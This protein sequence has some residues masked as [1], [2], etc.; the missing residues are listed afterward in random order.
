MKYEPI[1]IKDIAQALNLSISTVSRALRDSYEISQETKRLVME[2]AEKMNYRPNPV[3][4]SL[5]ERRTRSIGIV[6]S[7]IANSFFSQAIN[8][9]ESIA[10]EKGYTVIITQTNESGDR[11]MD[12]I[13]DLASRSVDGLLISLSCETT[14]ISHLKSM[15]E[16][17]MPMVF[18]DRV[19][20]GI[21]THK[22]VSDNY[23]GAFDATEH[24]IQSGYSR[25]AFL[26]N[27]PHLSII[28]ERLAGY[29]DALARY[30]RKPDEALIK[31]C[32]HGGLIYKEAEDALAQLLKLKKKPDAVL[33][34]ADKLTTNCLRYFHSRNIRV[35]D[36][37]AL[38][39]FSNL[40][41]TELLRP[42][43]SVIRQPAFEIG[44]QATELLLNILESKRPVRSFE[45]RS[46]PS[47]LI[48][49]ETSAKRQLA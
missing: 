34:C 32:A 40:D 26:G 33:A 7:E 45:Q 30:N 29:H 35:P 5:K 31:Y 28:K 1:T 15:H 39:G 11:E 27:A 41:L 19:P 6:V 4:L 16:R 21:D 36:D 24:L 3:A 25:I 12:N 13:R 20:E 38:V 49:R 8:G 44:Q 22:V 14:H 37:I 18:F 47:Q 42:S 43:L 46:L 10:R 9:I 23:K 48:I 2:Y 17:G